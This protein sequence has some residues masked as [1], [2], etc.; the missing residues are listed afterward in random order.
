[1]TTNLLI[2]A[3][4]IERDAFDRNC[5]HAIELMIDAVDHDA[6]ETKHAIARV[7]Y[8]IDSFRESFC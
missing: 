7:R 8:A 6:I 3:R 1:M 5:V 2:I 4:L